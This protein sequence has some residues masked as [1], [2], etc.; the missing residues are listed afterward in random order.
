MTEE[1]IRSEIL[2]EAQAITHRDRNQTNGDPGPHFVQLARLW[3]A[4][5][6][7]DI[8]PQD[9]AALLILL[10]V[11]RL[12]RSPGERDHWVDICGYAACGAE[13]VV[14][15][16]RVGLAIEPRAPEEAWRSMALYE[17]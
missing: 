4:Y 13:S 16:Q 15:S 5:L 17:T 14:Y 12:S 1:T 3:S 2:G 11:S 7:T 9:V 10:K 8:G 6:G